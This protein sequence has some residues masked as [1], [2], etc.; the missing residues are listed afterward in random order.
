MA[1]TSEKN[2]EMVSASAVPSEEVDRST[3]TNKLHTDQGP[4][5]VNDDKNNEK[6][7]IAVRDGAGAAIR[8]ETIAVQ[9]TGDATALSEEPGRE[10]RYTPRFGPELSQSKAHTMRLSMMASLQRETEPIMSALLGTSNAAESEQDY[11]IKNSFTLLISQ[12]P[13]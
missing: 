4:E 2:T 6:T 13:M 1:S 8:S 5:A 3:A 11:P 9:G 7:E 10:M 12:E